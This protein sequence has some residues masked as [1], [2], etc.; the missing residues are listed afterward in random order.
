MVRKSGIALS[1]LIASALFLSAA[2]GN[3]TSENQRRAKPHKKNP[4]EQSESI[5][6]QQPE[7]PLSVWQN[8][9]AALSEA[10]GTIKQQSI[11]AEKQAESYKETWYSPAVEIQIVLAAVGIGYLVF[12]A[13]QRLAIKG[14]ADISLRLLR[15]EHRPRIR[16]RTLNITQELRLD[17]PLEVGLR[18][19][20]VGST[21]ATIIA[22]NFTVG[23]QGVTVFA[24]TPARDVSPSPPQSPWR[25]YTMAPE[26]YDGDLH[27]METYL[28][29]PILKPG[30][31]YLVRKERK[32]L[33]IQPHEWERIKS[34]HFVIYASGFIFYR[35][36]AGQ[37][38]KT[39]FCRRLDPYLRFRKVDDPDLEYED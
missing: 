33:A 14:Q 20:N 9:N 13:L 11:V 6:Q 5:K 1:I 32:P 35:D 36:E 2:S 16:V 30:I 34:G 7:V 26:P 37:H 28:R 21:H 10:L 17:G 23:V 3:A 4:A 27:F 39:A 31:E 19:A 18:L 24:S 15:L 22:S 38:H 25:Y 29:D 12:A 8:T